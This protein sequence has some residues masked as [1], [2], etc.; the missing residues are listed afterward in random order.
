MLTAAGNLSCRFLDGNFS[1]WTQ[2]LALIFVLF[3]PDVVVMTS[4]PNSIDPV[5]NA[6]LFL[7]MAIFTVDLILSL[8]CRP[9]FSLLEVCLPERDGCPVLQKFH[10]LLV[11]AA[12]L[13][14]LT[15]TENKL[16]D[17]TIAPSPP[18][19]LDQHNKALRKC[20][21]LQVF[22]NLVTT[23]LIALD[24]SWV[25][26][27]VRQNES[28]GYSSLTR[29]LVLASQ[30][31]RMTRL[32]R[33]MRLVGVFRVSAMHAS[34]PAQKCGGFIGILNMWEACLSAPLWDAEVQPQAIIGVHSGG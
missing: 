25:Q 18:G 20:S 33:V 3:G 12:R 19:H 31:G 15:I 23:A 13:K 6:L 21:S 5:I 1:Q 9:R 16:F 32:L 28:T 7:S 27:Q 29:A 17:I 24:L 30:A 10:L 26:D 4:A 8:A 11:L 22:M 14:T 2:A 34:P